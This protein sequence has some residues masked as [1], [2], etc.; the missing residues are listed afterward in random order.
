MDL[1][2]STSMHSDPSN[3]SSYTLNLSSDSMDVPAMVAGANSRSSSVSSSGPRVRKSRKESSRE[4][5]PIPKAIV[6]AHQPGRSSR[7]I[8]MGP[9]TP[10]S[11][12][13]VQGGLR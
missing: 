11:T 8:E 4:R 10:I 9:S 13:E 2:F 1:I 3:P 6:P 5:I 7:D 12:P